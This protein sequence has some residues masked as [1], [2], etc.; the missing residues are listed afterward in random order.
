MKETFVTLQTEET[1]SIKE[2]ASKIVESVPPSKIPDLVKEIDELV[3]NWDITMKLYDFFKR[4][5]R[6]YR[7]EV[8]EDSDTLRVIEEV[9]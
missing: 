2:L 1:L 8:L 5:E 6:I 7:K 9:K 3:G 4:E